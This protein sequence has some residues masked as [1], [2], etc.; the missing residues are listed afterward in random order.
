MIWK[1]F[2]FEVFETFYV[3][4]LEKGGKMY[5]FKKEEE[6]ILKA[7]GNGVKNRAGLGWGR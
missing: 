5:F 4:P 3:L 6:D 1:S 2:I 7:A